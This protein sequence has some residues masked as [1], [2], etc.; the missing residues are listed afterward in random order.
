MRRFFS[1]LTVDCK[2]Y[3]PDYR[4][5]TVFFMKDLLSGERKALKLDEVKHLYVPYYKSLTI[6]SML[7]FCA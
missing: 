5:I 4:S 6:E 2:F 1:L 3:L 7:G